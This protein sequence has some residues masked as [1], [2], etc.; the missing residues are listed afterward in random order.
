MAKGRGHPVTPSIFPATWSAQVT[1]LRLPAE[2]N[3]EEEKRC[4]ALTM[5]EERPSPS[6]VPGGS[7]KKTIPASAPVPA[8]AHAAKH[9]HR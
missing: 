9:D 6:S 7:A 8:V 4:E 3:P 1:R 5:G 2:L